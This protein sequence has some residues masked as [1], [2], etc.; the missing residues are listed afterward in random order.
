MLIS[1]TL[2][3]VGPIP[4]VSKRGARAVDSTWPSGYDVRGHE[5]ALLQHWSA[6]TLR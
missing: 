3:A 2:H 4:K 1:A 6:D 5:P